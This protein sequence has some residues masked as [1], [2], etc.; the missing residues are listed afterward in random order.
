MKLLNVSLLSCLTSE[1][2]AIAAKKAAQIVEY[3]ILLWAN[4]QLKVGW[5]GGT[6]E[7][8]V[9]FYFQVEGALYLVGQ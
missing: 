5:E 3:L 8:R 9:S 1:A 7:W 6:D 2:P 4:V